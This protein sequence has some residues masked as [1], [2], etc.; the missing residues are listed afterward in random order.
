MKIKPEESTYTLSNFNL[1]KDKFPATKVHFNP[2]KPFKI[3]FY[4][5]FNHH[6]LA[7]IEDEELKVIEIDFGIKDK[8]IISI[9]QTE[10]SRI[11]WN[12]YSSF[13]GDPSV[14]DRYIKGQIYHIYFEINNNK[15]TIERDKMIISGRYNGDDDKITSFQII[16]NKE[17]LIAPGIINYFIVSYSGPI[18]KQV[19]FPLG[20]K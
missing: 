6:A 1:R 16:N 3:E 12:F 8:L 20:L 11:K 15:I 7:V 19:K 9:Q 18:A 13:I 14:E 5:Q 17:Q 2:I 10:S 4:V